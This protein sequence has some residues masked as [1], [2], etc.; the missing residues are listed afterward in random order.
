MKERRE[1]DIFI[2]LQVSLTAN[3]LTEEIISSYSEDV[4]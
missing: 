4:L 2:C 1:A 3:G